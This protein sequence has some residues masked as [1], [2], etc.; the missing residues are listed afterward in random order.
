[1]ALSR[2]FC[3]DCNRVRLTAKGDLVLCLGQQ[4]RVSLR[5]GL[6]AGL[7]DEAMKDLIRDA[8]ARKPR[9]HDFNEDRSRVSL[10]HMS[11]L[12]G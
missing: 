12:G 1:S 4:D 10:R 5:D 6:R 7:N 9:S 8:I 3:D 2:H 11:S